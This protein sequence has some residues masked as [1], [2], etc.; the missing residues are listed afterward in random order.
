MPEETNTNTDAS[1]PKRSRSAQDKMIE[2]YIADAK[3]FLKVATEDE[4]IRPI[5]EAHGYD[6]AEF[7]EGLALADAADSAYQGRAAGM[8][9]QKLTGEALLAAIQKAREDYAAFREIARAAFPDEADRITL[10]LK[11]EVP[12]DTERFITVAEASYAA[13]RKDP[14]ATKMSKRGYPATRLATLQQDLD[15]LTAE[16]GE[17]DQAQGEAIDD[18]AI[19]NAAYKALKTYMKELKG[20]ARGALRKKPGLQAKLG[21]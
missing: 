8:G 4:E 19:R 7:D 11:G 9:K 18:T 1:K 20:I 3:K 14:Q 5:L 17:Q 15:D 6:Q 2:A 10:G 21:L 12:D 13:A 16:S